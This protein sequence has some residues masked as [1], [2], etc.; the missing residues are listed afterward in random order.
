[1][2]MTVLQAPITSAEKTTDEEATEDLR[3]PYEAPRVIK[4]RTV[5]R[6]TLFSVMGPAMTGITAMG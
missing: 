3:K 6:A 4:K 5:A 1:M 2:T